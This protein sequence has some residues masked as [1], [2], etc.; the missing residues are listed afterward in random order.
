MASSLSPA[1]AREWVVVFGEVGADYTRPLDFAK[2]NL[3]AHEF[4]NPT[5]IIQFC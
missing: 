5:E 1:C 4:E 3:A 2:H